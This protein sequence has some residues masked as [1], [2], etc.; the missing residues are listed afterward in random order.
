VHE[1]AVVALGREQHDERAAG[2]AQPAAQ[3]KA[4]GTQRAA[5]EK[6]RKAKQPG[7]VRSL[8]WS[9]R[10]TWVMLGEM[11]NLVVEID[12]KENMEEGPMMANTKLL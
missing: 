3:R 2:A 7:R 1:Q 12:V 8:T 5:A 11:G 10:V 6:Q 9:Y 4:A